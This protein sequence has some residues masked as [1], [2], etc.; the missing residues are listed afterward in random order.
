MQVFLNQQTR[1]GMQKLLSDKF[2]GSSK[3]NL[4]FLEMLEPS[5]F[6]NWNM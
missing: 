6:W 2:G 1:L 3:Q 5:Y 4:I